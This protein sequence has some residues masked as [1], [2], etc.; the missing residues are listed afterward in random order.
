MKRTWDNYKI[1]KGPNA[2][3][4]IAQESAELA[5]M[6]KELSDLAK[7][8]QASTDEVAQVSAA[9]SQFTRLCAECESI[10][11]EFQSVLSRIGKR[12]RRPVDS[13]DE[14]AMRKITR[15]P[16]AGIWGAQKIEQMS[17]RLE[18]LRN[19]IMSSIIFCLWYV[20]DSLAVRLDT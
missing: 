2:A 13:E 1:Y 10:D 15:L 11:A 3:R 16:L 20:R 19:Q 14:K 12:K 17:E 4:Q 7:A 9:E 18:E 8:V 5:E 6:A